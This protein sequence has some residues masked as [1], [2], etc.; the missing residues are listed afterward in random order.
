MK[1]EFKKTSRAEDIFEYIKDG[2][3]AGMW[4]IGDRINDFELA[5]RLSVSRLSVREA[6]FKLAE[7]GILEK[8]QWKG[9]FV[10]SI[11]EQEIDSIIEIRFALE[12]VAIEH[13]IGSPSEEV[14]A[15]MERAITESEHEL[16]TGDHLTYLKKD[17]SF[18]E[19]LY[20][21]SG[22]P[23]IQKIISNLLV[24]INVMRNISMGP[25]EA[26]KETAL[27]SIRDHKE[28][29]QAVREGKK[30]DSLNILKRHF[31]THK[32]NIIIEL[33]KQ[34]VLSQEVL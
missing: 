27:S 11:D 22:N 6:L 8:I 15:R 9:Y 19:L 23:F 32:K 4:K 17:F 16:E 33:N 26:F 12:K 31:S 28:L 1:N 34:K 24:I 13:L 7:V 18:H 10:K 25:D 14:F 3:L 29:L 21:G 30:R 20:E 2:L 5:N